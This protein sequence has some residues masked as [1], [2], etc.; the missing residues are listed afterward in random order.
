[1]TLFTGWDIAVLIGVAKGTVEF[2]VSKVAFF[3]LVK[4]FAVATGTRLIGDL[5]TVEHDADIVDRVTLHAAGTAF[6]C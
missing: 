2:R 1:M 3:K 4:C 5:V 6:E